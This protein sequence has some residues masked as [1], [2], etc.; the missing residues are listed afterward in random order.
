MRI[1][2]FLAK[3]ISKYLAPAS[4]R[5]ATTKDNVNN[6]L[7][8]NLIKHHALVVVVAIIGV[9]IIM[10]V[11]LLL[12]SP[13]DDLKGKR[14]RLGLFS[15]T[16]ERLSEMHV[17]Y[18]NP[19]DYVAAFRP[20][21]LHSF[22][23]SSP[24]ERILIGASLEEIGAALL[25]APT[26]PNVRII[27]YD[28]ERWDRTPKEEQANKLASVYKAIEK[29]HA[30]GYKFAYTPDRQWLRDTYEQLDWRLVDYVTLQVQRANLTEALTIVADVRSAI[31][32]SDA[33]TIVFVQ[34]SPRF[35]SV[36]ETIA[37][38]NAMK[39]I[40]DGIAFVFS[41]T[42]ELEMIDIITKVGRAD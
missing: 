9:G 1:L 32:R 37:R 30:A 34:F 4:I 23:P 29:V 27:A 36:E 2:I 24:A 40:I 12:S 6:Y 5:L 28:P 16:T 10:F 14:F 38:I 31:D 13:S 21:I 7:H 8:D 22:D 20:E 41:P 18:S 19:G 26:I 39:D 33:S 11:A 15:A 35:T 3:I 25:M 17:Y 42:H